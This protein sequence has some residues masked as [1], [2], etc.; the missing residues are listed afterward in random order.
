MRHKGM[1]WRTLENGLITEKIPALLKLYQFLITLIFSH[2]FDLYIYWH[3]LSV[4]MDLI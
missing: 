2:S 1:G 4:S 3:L